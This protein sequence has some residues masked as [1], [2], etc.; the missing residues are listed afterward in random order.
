MICRLNSGP[1]SEMRRHASTGFVGQP[2]RAETSVSQLGAVP[3]GTRTSSTVGFP[4]LPCRA[5]AYRRYAAGAP[6]VSPCETKTDGH[7]HSDHSRPGME[8]TLVYH[9]STTPVLRSLWQPGAFRRCLPPSAKNAE[10]WG[11]HTVILH[12]RS[13]NWQRWD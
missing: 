9:L 12:H 5:F 1:P 4:A 3:Y 11:T 2:A 10:G 7:R 8:S 6:A 13:L